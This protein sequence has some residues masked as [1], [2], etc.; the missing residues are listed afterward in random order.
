MDP[1]KHPISNPYEA[2]ANALEHRV[3]A[4]NGSRQ[5]GFHPIAT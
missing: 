4:V 2:I 1:A 3:G 5:S